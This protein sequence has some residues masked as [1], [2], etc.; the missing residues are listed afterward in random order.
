MMTDFLCLE[1]RMGTLLMTMMMNDDDDDND[2][3]EDIVE[4]EM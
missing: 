1:L 4:D 3:A 2:D